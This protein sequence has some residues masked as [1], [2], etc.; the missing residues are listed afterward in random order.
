MRNQRYFTACLMLLL[1]LFGQIA[2]AQNTKK[3][4]FARYENGGTF[5]FS[6]SL[7]PKARERMKSEMREFLWEHWKQKRLAHV[8]ATFYTIEGDPTTHNLYIEPDEN[9]HWH[10]VSEYKR[11]CCWFYAMEKKKRK[12]ERR[13]GT[14]IYD[15][16]ERIEEIKNGKVT[17]KVI[18]DGYR[19][20]PSVYRI[21]LRNA[22]ENNSSEAAFI[23]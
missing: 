16:V 14:D 17:W 23:L 15:T 19:R 2:L 7:G 21:R 6:W 5:D 18:S 1:M 10:V 8:V 20:A 3:R 13:K 22:A 12:R 11:E 4:D 9:G